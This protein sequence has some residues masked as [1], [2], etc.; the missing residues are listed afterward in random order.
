MRKEKQKQK[1]KQSKLTKGNNSI[2]SLKEKLNTIRRRLKNM[3]YRRK[4]S[5]LDFKMSFGRLD[6]SKKWQENQYHSSRKLFMIVD[7]WQLGMTCNQLFKTLTVPMTGVSYKFFL[8]FNTYNGN[9]LFYL[10]IMIK[11]YTIKI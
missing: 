3:Q 2:L 10:S 9:Y 1:Q 11:N 7:Y 8:F 5:Q 4:L 6:K